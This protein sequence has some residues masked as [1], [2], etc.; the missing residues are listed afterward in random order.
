M[1]KISLKNLHL[2]E[3]ELLS[4]EQ[5][6]EVLGGVGGSTIGT[7]TTE[8]CSVNCVADGGS[9]TSSDCKTGTCSYN[10]TYLVCI[11]N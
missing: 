5:L 9:C 3:I 7:T 8:D 11:L 6:K 4:R 2:K 1:K 10:D